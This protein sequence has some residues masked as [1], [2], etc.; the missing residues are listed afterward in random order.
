MTDRE[1]LRTALSRLGLL[2]ADYAGLIAACR[3]SVAAASLGAADP[4]VYVRDLLA[5]RGQLPGPGA[6]PLTVLA[7][8]RAALHMAGWPAV[9]RDG[10]VTPTTAPWPRHDDVPVLD[11]APMV[12]RPGTADPAPPQGAPCG[13][14]DLPP[15]G[16][17]GASG[18]GRASFCPDHRGHR[19]V[20]RLGAVAVY[21][22]VLDGLP[23]SAGQAREWAGRILNGCPAAWPAVQALDELV[24]NAVTHS[25]SAGRPGSVRVRLIIAPDAWVRAEI[26]DDGPAK[27]THADIHAAMVIDRRRLYNTGSGGLAEGG[28]GLKIVG[29]LSRSSG[30]AAGA[31]WF[32][33][34]WNPPSDL[35]PDHSPR[36]NLTVKEHA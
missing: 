30:R 4:L 29:A 21:E 13:C 12:I 3:A 8:R 16:P 28:R 32:V 27:N 5:G 34:P 33:L 24:V 18:A 26:S 6:S 11:L 35:A 1:E 19:G 22:R 7:D 10:H 25:A 23:V 15:L 17:A 36:Q 9:R 31:A 2:C 14:L 20:P